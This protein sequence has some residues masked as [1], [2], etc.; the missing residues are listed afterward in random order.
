MSSHTNLPIPSNLIPSNLIPSKPILLILG[1]G[2]NI[3]RSLATHFSTNGFL[4]ASVSRS[5][6]NSLSPDGTH[7]SIQADLSDTGC[8]EGIFEKVLSTWGGAPSV[9][10][11]NATSR[12]LLP[13]DDPLSTSASTSTNPDSTLSSPSAFSPAQFT[14]DLTVNITSA[15]TA[16]HHAIR[17]FKSLPPSP[18]KTFIYTGNRLPAMAK[19]EVL[20][21]GMCKAAVAKM[22][23]DLGVGYA[24]EGYK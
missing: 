10:V 2:T 17:G 8:V 18:L 22:V 20:Y 4:V 12:T 11:Y 14:H 15:L 16:A 21:F 23:W 19:P 6:T 24:G 3:G 9:V 7:L 13:S 1:S 5:K